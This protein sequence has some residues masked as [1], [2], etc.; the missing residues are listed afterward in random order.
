M[1]T[2]LPPKN[3]T[4]LTMNVIDHIFI[5][6]LPQ[7]TNALIRQHFSYFVINQ[8]RDHD[9]RSPR[10]RTTSHIISVYLEH[11]KETP[12]LL[13]A[14]NYLRPAQ[15]MKLYHLIIKAWNKV[16]VTLLQRSRNV[17]TIV[18]ALVYN[19][20]IVLEPCVPTLVQTFMHAY[21]LW[22]ILLQL[23]FFFQLDNLICFFQFSIVLFIN[24][25]QLLR[26]KHTGLVLPTT[27][28]L[29]SCL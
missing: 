21:H 12:D 13:A 24:V 20:C 28:Y 17:Q 26:K 14:L 15:N 5:C 10:S 2:L 9:R 22:F 27:L 25:K 8:Q 16:Y 29:F 3:Y 6:I 23:Q 7:S 1:V 11:A 4:R 19:R 18:K